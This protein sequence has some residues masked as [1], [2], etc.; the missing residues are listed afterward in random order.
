MNTI[1]QWWAVL[2]AVCS[3]SLLGGCAFAAPPVPTSSNADLG[4]EALDGAPAT[5]PF[6]DV[7]RTGDR[8]TIRI[9]REPDLSQDAAL[10]D[11]AGQ[12]QMALL[13][14]VPAAGLSPSEFAQRL[15]ALYAAR[16]LAAPSVVVTPLSFAVR[17]VTVTGAV[18]KPGIYDMAART[19]L[20]DAIALAQGPNN[21]ARF[22]QVAVVR[23]FSGDDAHLGRKVAI[24]NLS[25]IYAGTQADIEILPGDQIIVGTSTLKKIYRDLLIAGPFL[26]LFRPY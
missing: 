11:Q 2:I 23:R 12:V 1:G 13:G 19:S 17:R 20:I 26:S 25:H 15:E 14:P 8:L 9:F 3:A 7:I 24:F 22:S 5:E 10:V 16:Y 21:V 18:G 6:S 4:F